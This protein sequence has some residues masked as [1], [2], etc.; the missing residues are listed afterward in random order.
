MKVLII[1]LFKAQNLVPRDYSKCIHMHTHTLTHT[2]R[3]PHTEAFQPRKAKIYTAQNGQQ[4]PRRP[5]MDED[6]S[7]EQKTWQVYNLGKEM[8]LD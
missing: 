6:I 4:T 5:G 1:I 8:F 7:T 3:C 2:Q